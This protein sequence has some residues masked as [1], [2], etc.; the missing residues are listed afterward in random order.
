MSNTLK[1][2][3]SFFVRFQTVFSNSNW[4]ER[5]S[6]DRS[7]SGSQPSNEDLTAWHRYCFQLPLSALMECKQ[8]YLDPSA[9]LLVLEGKD[10][11]VAEFVVRKKVSGS[12]SSSGQRSPVRVLLEGSDK[13]LDIVTQQV[14]SHSQYYCG[15]VLI[16][17]FDFCLI[18]LLS[19]FLEYSFEE[20]ILLL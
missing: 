20:N 5:I 18:F 12:R 19:Y 9:S 14:R 15:R 13:S 2:V 16:Y 11:S 6:F 4:M 7:S 8:Q 10:G 1:F 17:L 3:V